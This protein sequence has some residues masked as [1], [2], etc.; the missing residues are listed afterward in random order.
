VGKQAENA[1]PSA[2]SGTAEAV[3]KARSNLEFGIL[4]CEKKIMNLLSERT[5]T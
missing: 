2:G 1:V 4:F 3:I 5:R